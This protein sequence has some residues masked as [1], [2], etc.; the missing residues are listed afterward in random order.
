[1]NPIPWTRIAGTA[2]NAIRRTMNVTRTMVRHA[3]NRQALRN[4][5]STRTCARLGVCAISP[6]RDW[7]RF[8][9]AWDEADVGA[10]RRNVPLLGLDVLN[11]GAGPGHDAFGEW[12]VAQRF[13]VLLS[14]GESVLD[15]ILHRLQLCLI[16]VLLVADQPRVGDD[17]IGLSGVGI[18]RPRDHVV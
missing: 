1:R 9:R 6:G 10:R 16:P 5:R 15:Q 11:S 17:R 13:G 8:E 7:N 14:F 4:A 3:N 12:N 2:A 18:G